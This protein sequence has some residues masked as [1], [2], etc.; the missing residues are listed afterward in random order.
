MPRIDR[1][2]ELSIFSPSS[3]VRK[4]SE[5]R[6]PDSSFMTLLQ[7]IEQQDLKERLDHLLDAIDVRA[8]LLKE[9]LTEENLLAYQLI[10]GEF[11]KVI[12]KE[13]LKTRETMT[14]GQDGTLRILKI[15]DHIHGE[16]EELKSM[17]LDREVS[18]FKIMERLDRIRGLLLD[19]YT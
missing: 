8:Q 15:I 14:R 11:L 4:A 10:M 17:V 13:Y 19:I 7:G 12:N 6:G 5:K 16:M 3:P 18:Q 9:R 2:K 1:K